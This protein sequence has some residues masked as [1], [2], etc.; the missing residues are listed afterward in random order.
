M[1]TDVIVVTCAEP[2]AVPFL[3]SLPREDL[4]RAT[5]FATRDVVASAIRQTPVGTSHIIGGASAVGE[6][7]SLAG[8][9]QRHVT[10]VVA[11]D[12]WGPYRG[13][14]FVRA[15]ILAP[16]FLSPTGRADLV[17]LRGDGRSFKAECDLS[18]RALLQ[19]MYSR[20]A[21]LLRDYVGRGALRTGCR[22]AKAALSI[23]VA[24]I[25]LGRVTL[26]IL[27]TELDARERTGRR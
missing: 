11:P 8:D 20:E 16:W 6:V 17:E 27:R 15:R 26:F 25:T 5:L 10:V 12:P 9:T 23:P 4:T 22:L 24:T 3:R 14:G 1:R 7:R 13:R 2:D 21:H 19:R 18:R